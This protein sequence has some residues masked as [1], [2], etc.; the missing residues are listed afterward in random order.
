MDDVSTS[1]TPK[2]FRIRINQ[3]C[4]FKFYENSFLVFC[5]VRHCVYVSVYRASS[6]QGRDTYSVGRM[7]VCVCVRNEK[8]STCHI[9]IFQKSTEDNFWF[10]INRYKNRI[11]TPI[12]KEH[13][14]CYSTMAKCQVFVHIRIRDVQDQFE[15]S[16]GH[17]TI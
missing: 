12:K 13:W 11:L 6:T 9:L 16:S 5:D 4:Y 7:C 1:R 8:Y 15:A 14:K 17:L 3:Y 10:L 2:P